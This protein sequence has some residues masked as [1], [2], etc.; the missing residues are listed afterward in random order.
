M[1][2]AAAVLVQ[3]EGRRRPV[4]LLS[5]EAG[6][7]KSRLAAA[8]LERLAGEPHTRLRCFCSP[9]HTDSALYPIIGQMET[10]LMFARGPSDRRAV[11]SV[12]GALD[13]APIPTLRDGGV[14]H[15]QASRGTAW[16]TRAMNVANSDM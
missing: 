7:G 11:A 5:G 9:Q 13:D 1:R 15:D 10:V 14:P 4:V 2:M 12:A 3:G 8:L 6:I 16:S